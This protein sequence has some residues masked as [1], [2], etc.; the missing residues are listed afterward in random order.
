MNEGLLI[1]TN[2]YIY[3]EYIPEIG[4]RVVLS[5][6]GKKWVGA[7]AR[8]THPVDFDTVGITTE[9]INVSTKYVCCEFEMKINWANGLSGQYPMSFLK[10]AKE[11]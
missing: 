2:K 7:F 3:E 10:K 11:K 4:D 1:L 6:L 9:K 8:F 5:E